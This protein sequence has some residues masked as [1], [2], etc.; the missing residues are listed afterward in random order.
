MQL[1]CQ[2]CRNGVARG[3]EKWLANMRGKRAPNGVRARGMYSAARGTLAKHAFAMPKRLDTRLPLGRGPGAGP[4]PEPG[5][6][7]TQLD[8]QKP[9]RGVGGQRPRPYTPLSALVIYVN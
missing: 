8:S 6:V 2:R 4:G 9:K 1:K 5:A 7:L 3:R